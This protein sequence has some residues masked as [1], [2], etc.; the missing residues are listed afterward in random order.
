MSLSQ[1]S[2]GYTSTQWSSVV[3]SNKI[4]SQLPAVG[5]CNVHRG[6]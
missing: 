2:V 5:Y 3:E 1:T 4:R 6:L